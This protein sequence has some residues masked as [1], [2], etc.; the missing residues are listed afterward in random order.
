MTRFQ[1]LDSVP[2][3]PWR[4]LSFHFLTRLSHLLLNLRLFVYLTDADHF[5]KQR[6]LRLLLAMLLIDT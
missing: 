6:L 2:V 1:G 4:L 3:K 5:Q